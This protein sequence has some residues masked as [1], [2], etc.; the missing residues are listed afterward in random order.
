VRERRT[1]DWE[2]LIESVGEGVD[3]MG[4]HG[5]LVEKLWYNQDSKAEDGSQDESTH[6]ADV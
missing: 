2:E 5:V 4:A 6:I 1:R 3:G